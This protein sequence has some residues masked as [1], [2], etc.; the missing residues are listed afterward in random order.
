MKSQY[1][2]I[3]KPLLSTLQY[4]GMPRGQKFYLLKE[5][6]VGKYILEGKVLEQCMVVDHSPYRLMLQ[7][8]L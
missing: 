3:F 7:G 4:A 1:W 6:A 5:G 2:L 8:D